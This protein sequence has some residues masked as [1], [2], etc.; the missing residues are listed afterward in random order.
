MDLDLGVTWLED[1][2]YHRAYLGEVPV[3][4]IFSGE[5]GYTWWVRSPDQGVK[6]TFRT[7][8]GNGRLELCQAKAHVIQALVKLGWEQ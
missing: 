3:A 6:G 2:K 8:T 1:F 4:W 7:V 5:R